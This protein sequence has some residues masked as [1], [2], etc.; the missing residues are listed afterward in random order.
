MHKKLTLITTLFVLFSLLTSTTCNKN[1]TLFEIGEVG[2]SF[3][4]MTE[5]SIYEDSLKPIFD[6]TVIMQ[7]NI[8]PKYIYTNNVNFSLIKT[9][10]AFSPIDRTLN[11][12]ISEL[13]ISSSRDF[14]DKTA[15]ENI[16]EYLVYLEGGY[17]DYV[18]STWIYQ[19]TMSVQD[20]V[21]KHLKQGTYEYE[22]YSSKFKF[23]KRP[24][25][26]KQV[27]YFDFINSQ[28]AHYFGQSDTLWI[29]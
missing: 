14:Y 19:D 1:G 9:A 17:Y 4:G 10:N 23:K 16:N 25:V 29:E 22:L 21:Y 20:Y 28:G 7:L 5:F 27:L 24:P 2:A 11:H 12:S 8:H 6:D 18:D 15:G 13:I 3:T 26:G